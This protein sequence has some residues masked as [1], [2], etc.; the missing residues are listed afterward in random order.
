MKRYLFVGL[1]I[2]AT[3]SAVAVPAAAEP[4]GEATFRQPSRQV[5]RRPALADF[6]GSKIDL[7]KGWG[8]AQA[9]VV[10]RGAGLL[11]CYRTEQAM[12][13]EIQALLESSP[14]A[15]ASSCASP[16][17]LYEHGNYGGRQLLFY[18]RSFWQNLDAYGFGAHLSSYKVGACN[19]HLA[20]FNDGYGYWYPGNTSAY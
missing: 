8:E 2:L 15:A 18:D 12:E 4:G 19:S 5:E 7:S 6:E 3:A 20:D 11:K 9:C 16:L 10:A 17:R 13:L 14:A 1:F